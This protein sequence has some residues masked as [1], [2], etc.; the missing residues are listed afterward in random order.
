MGLDAPDH[1][2]P[3][4]VVMIMTYQFYDP[5][6]GPA[7][8]IGVGDSGHFFI[9]DRI[10]QKPGRFLYNAAAVRPDDYSAYPLP[11]L[12]APTKSILNIVMDLVAGAASYSV[13]R[14]L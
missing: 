11:R 12:P 3:L 13:S 9:G 8:T 5:L 1:H 7:V 4:R 6:T 14:A 10:I 2:D